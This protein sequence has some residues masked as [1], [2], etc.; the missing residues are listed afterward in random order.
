[1]GSLGYEAFRFEPGGENIFSKR[2][3]DKHND[4]RQMLMPGV[5]STTLQTCPDLTH[6]VEQYSGR[7]FPGME[8]SVDTEVLNLIKLLECKYISTSNDFR[9]VDMSHKFRLFTL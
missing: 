8:D 6:L 2:D 3:D 5:G 1:M 7:D 9:P 4:T